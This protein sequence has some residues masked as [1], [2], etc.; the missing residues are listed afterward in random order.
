MAPTKTATP[1]ASSEPSTFRATAYK[2][3]GP[4]KRSSRVP[5][6]IAWQP[7]LSGTIPPLS[8]SG[9][10]D[11]ILLYL[12]SNDLS[13]TLPPSIGTLSKLRQLHVGANSLSGTIPTEYAKLQQLGDFRIFNNHISGSLPSQVG[14]APSPQFPTPPNV[15]ASSALAPTATNAAVRFVVS[16][17]RV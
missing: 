13:G 9:L 14:A 16:S 10:D 12:Q 11:L 7:L 3:G 6:L 2:V 4:R 5:R 1:A 15:K 8:S 17:P